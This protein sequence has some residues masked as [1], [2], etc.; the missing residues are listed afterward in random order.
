MEL[1]NEI[2]WNI[3]KYMSHPCA[4]MITDEI[5]FYNSIEWPLE[6]QADVPSFLE[7]ALQKVMLSKINNRLEKAGKTFNMEQYYKQC[8]QSVK[9]Y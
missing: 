2:Y 5:N 9:Y 1:P 6:L 3:I 7:I 8:Y 4:D